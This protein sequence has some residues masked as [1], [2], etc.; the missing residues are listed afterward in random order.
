MM[1]PPLEWGCCTSGETGDGF[2]KCN[3]CKK[4]FH[5]ACVALSDHERGTVWYCPM[6]VPKNKK[7][8]NTLA[9]SGNNITFRAQ[10]RQAFSSPEQ[11]KSVPITSA[12]IRNIVQDVIKSEMRELLVDLTFNI[13]SELK[14]LKQDICEVKQSMDFIN[15]QYEDFMKENKATK[16]VVK[17]LQKENC[18]LK[19]N[20][21]QLNGRLNQLEQHARSNNI[22]LQCIPENK[23]EN[24]VSI[25]TQIGKTIGYAVTEENILNCTRIAKMNRDSARPRSII[26]QLS[27]PRVRDGYLAAAISFNKLKKN[28]SEKLNAEYL[29][30]NEGTPIFVTEHLSPANKALHA[31][32]RQRA[33]ANGYKYV[34]V[35]GG[36]IYARKS[37]NDEFL[38]IKD[39][40]YLDKL[41]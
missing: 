37:E 5:F 2:V 1:S 22:E 19:N 3:N 24:L 30:F 21:D 36:R 29:G 7:N 11:D 33:K 4:A 17:E 14:T 40:T 35:R 20:I 8:D 16:E 39:S 10:K 28:L 27:S 18:N 38:H 31:A 6:C 41:V 13:T 15:N 23:N 32:T 34:W 12:E 25:V 26:V 9:G